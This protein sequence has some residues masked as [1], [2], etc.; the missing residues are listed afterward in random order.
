MD[1]LLGDASKAKRILH[2]DPEVKFVE[3]VKGA[4]AVS[5]NDGSLAIAEFLSGS[6]EVFVH[7]M[8]K[9]A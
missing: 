2:W 8:D 3:L 7:L 9:R 1:I 4:A 6:E 5:A